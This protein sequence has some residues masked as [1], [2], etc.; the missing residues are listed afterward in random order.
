MNECHIVD[1]ETIHCEKCGEDIGKWIAVG[2]TPSQPPNCG[3]MIVEVL[4]P[5]GYT[6]D[7]QSGIFRQS[8]K[9]RRRKASGVPA[10]SYRADL[11]PIPQ[12]TLT[13]HFEAFAAFISQGTG[14]ES[15][16]SDQ[17][18]RNVT[19]YRICAPL[20][21]RIKCHSCRLDNSVTLDTA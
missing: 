10:N 4:L 5:A 20:P 12:S 19:N 14:T 7:R 6:F 11:V 1:G 9:A 3:S 2:A 18:D 8:K 16:A 15:I 13:T 21:A 17:R